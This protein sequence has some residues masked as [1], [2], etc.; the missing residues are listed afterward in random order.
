MVHN[1][2]INGA[3]HNRIRQTIQNNNK[4][5]QEAQKVI[6]DTSDKIKIAAQNH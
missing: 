1:W 3:G 6:I 4:L 2:G 5:Y